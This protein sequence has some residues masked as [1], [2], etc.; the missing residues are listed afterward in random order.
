MMT[1]KLF[2][3]LWNFKIFNDYDFKDVEGNSIEILDFGKWNPNSGP[4]F[5]LGKIRTKDL[6][7]AGNIELHLK[8][9]DWIFHRHSGNPDFENIV[10]HAVF[11]HDC[12]IEDL[13]NKNIPTLELKNHID[14]NLLQKYEMMMQENSFIPCEKIFDAEKIPINF[15]EGKLLEKLDEK[16]EELEQ[17]LKIFKNNYEAILFHQLAYAF[18]LKVNAEIFKNSAESIDFSVIQKIR[19]NPVQLE[20]LFF[21]KSGW[22]NHSEDDYMNIRKREYDFLKTKHGISDVVFS[23][24]FLRLRPPNFPTIRL[25]QFANLYHSQQNLFSKIINAE[26]VE[27]LYQI[28]KNV[29]ADEYWNCRFN[30][31]K[32]SETENE[33]FLTKDF[34]DLIIINAVL[35]LKYV[36]HRNHNEEIQDEILTFYQKIAP[37]K[38]TIINQWKNLGVKMESSM[39]T[40]A[41]I[42]H[43]KNF[44]TKKKCLNCGI[45]LQLLK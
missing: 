9:S 44:C 30:F 41:F 16:A 18:G 7:L 22:L 2:Q 39:K 33:K 36:Y 38:N 35:P 13:K 21:G 34:I 29:K 40:Q 1:E 10:L 19:Q 11:I 45:G 23:P 43:F 37:E 31:G 3:Y 28:F 42:Y 8:S 32:I 12:E 26:N 27:E 6:V 17:K 14:K 25:S 15:C 5:L 24:K 4:D 20:A